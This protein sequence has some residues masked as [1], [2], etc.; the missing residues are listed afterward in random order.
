[1]VKFDAAL[2]SGSLLRPETLQQMWTPTTLKNGKIVRIEQM[3]YGLGWFVLSVA[4][5]RIVAH[6][7][8]TGTF[9]LK[10]P[11]DRVTIILLSN[12]DAGSGS[13]SDSDLIHSPLGSFHL[14]HSPAKA[15]NFPPSTS[16]QYGELYARSQQNR[17]GHKSSGAN[18]LRT[19][20]WL[21]GM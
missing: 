15:N 12:L 3:P 17:A 18:Y 20:G 4:G 13:A 10:F 14:S 6:P 5:H 7:G 1:M 8:W 19:Q 11:D 9:Y 2:S 21:T 16:K